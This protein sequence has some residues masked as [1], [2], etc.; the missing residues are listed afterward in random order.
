[1]PVLA[2]YNSFIGTHWETGSIANTLAHRGVTAPH[3][4]QP[5]SEALLM[6]VGGGAVMG[7]FSFAYEGY[8]PQ[9]RILTRNTFDPWDALL[10]RLGVVQHVQP[11]P[12]PPLASA[13][14]LTPGARCPWPCCPTPWNP[15]VITAP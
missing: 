1:M 12:R 3:T 15:S 11:C 6:G 13:P 10:S 9:A 4:G 2:D 7:Y 8:D 5:Y 14:P